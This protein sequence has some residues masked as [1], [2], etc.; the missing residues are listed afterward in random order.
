[1][2]LFVGPAIVTTQDAG[3]A[4]TLLQSLAGST[5]DSSQLVLTA[6]M[7]FMTVTEDKLQ[8]LRDKHRP[9]IL[10]V[11]DER[12]R[13]SQVWKDSKGLAA[14][15]YSFKHPP[16]KL[17]EI[18]YTGEADMG[19]YGSHLES[20]SPRGDN[21]LSRTGVDG[22]IDSI[23]DLQEQVAYFIFQEIIKPWSLGKLLEFPFYFIIW[24]HI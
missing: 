20:P 11:I 5:F 9:S 21:F 15:L 16:G 1:M 8:E 17:E 3:D 10:N 23:P 13:A 22:D 24:R 4:I 7:G 14:K 19:S 12:A 18:K 6:C 2:F